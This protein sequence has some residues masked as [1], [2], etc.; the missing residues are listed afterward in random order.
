[1]KDKIK[2]IIKSIIIFTLYFSFSY[3]VTFIL[4]ITGIDISKLNIMYRIGFIYIIELIPLIGLIL[5]YKKDLK[6]DLNDFKPNIEKYADKYIK[7]WLLGIFLMGIANIII[8]TI[9]KTD[10]SSNETAIRE[11]TKILPIYSIMSTCIVAPI[12]E[13]LAFR[14]TVNNIFINKKLSIFMGFLL[15]GLSHVVGTYS[16]LLDLLYIIPYGILGGIFMYI[17]T[18]SENIFTTITL[19]FIHNTI[20]MILYFISGAV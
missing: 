12:A 13:E 1:M 18:D 10:N 11:I 17:Y 2:K 19:H 16:G 20:L 5:I 6:K 7:Y 15:F 3:I 14:K 9:T 4:T 8:S